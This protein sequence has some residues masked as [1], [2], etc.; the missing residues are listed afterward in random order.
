[1]LSSWDT[2][3]RVRAAW[4]RHWAHRLAALQKQSHSMIWIQAIFVPLLR[5][6][7]TRASPDRQVTGRPYGTALPAIAL[8]G[9]AA[10]CKSQLR[11]ISFLAAF[12]NTAVLEYSLVTL[13]HRPG[14]STRY[15]QLVL[16][17]SVEEL[18]YVQVTFRISSEKQTCTGQL[19]SC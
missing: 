13:L 15:A 10:L 11:P 12:W 7:Q 14:E 1:M 9:R 6:W 5:F 19:R 2:A 17:I 18:V 3:M 4:L 16:F 8:L